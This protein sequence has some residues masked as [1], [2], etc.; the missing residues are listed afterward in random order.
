MIAGGIYSFCHSA[1]C[2]TQSP[3]IT[4]LHSLDLWEI[5]LAVNQ[6]PLAKRFDSLRVHSRVSS[7][8]ERRGDHAKAEGASPSPLIAGGWVVGHC[9]TAC[10]RPGPGSFAWHGKE[11]GEELVSLASQVRFLPVPL[12]GD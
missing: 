5:S 9:L 8:A 11:S 7:V 6:V 4:V 10:L 12:M 2:S 1:G 3:A